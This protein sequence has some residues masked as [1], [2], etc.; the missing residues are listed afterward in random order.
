MGE[1]IPNADAF[2]FKLLDNSHAKDKHR[3]YQYGLPADSATPFYPRPPSQMRMPTAY[4]MQPVYPMSPMMQMPYMPG[5]ALP[6]V[7]LQPPFQPQMH[8][9]TN[10][11]VKDFHVFF[12]DRFLPDANWIHFGDLGQGYGECTT[13]GHPPFVRSTSFV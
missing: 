2:S 13:V 8:P 4:P 11:V 6:T 12:N 7:Q 9:P 10:Y 3:V 5:M 1:L